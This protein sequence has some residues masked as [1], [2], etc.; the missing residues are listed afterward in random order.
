MISEIPARAPAENALLL[1][2]GEAETRA[3]SDLYDRLSARVLGTVQCI[4][5]DRAQSEE[6]T[7]EVFLEV[8]QSASRY[9]QTRGSA[10]AWILT[11]A[12]RR[13]VDR[14]RAAQA[15]RDRDI[16]IGI[17]DHSVEFD[18]VVESVELRLESAR[19]RKAMTKL[20]VLQRQAVTMTYAEG[21]T[22]GETAALLRVP[23]GTV[24][25]RLR[26]GLIG[27]RL[28]LGPTR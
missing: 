18:D 7:Q 14:V 8:W 3:F 26:D 23:V 27:L 15:S 10:A 25:T 2:V 22:N 9:E 24:K 5:V 12:R 13:A 6:V 21:F 20:T 1:R 19:V 11:I 16:R 17:R 4:L 28:I